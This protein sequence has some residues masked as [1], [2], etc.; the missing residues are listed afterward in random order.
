MSRYL[1]VVPPLVGHVNPLVGV[2]A[3]LS[4]RGHDVAWAGSPELVT[5]LAGSAARVFPCAVPTTAAGELVA[6]PPELRGLAALKFLWEEFLAPLAE[7]MEPG[8][9]AAVQEFAPDV[10]V[11][12][13]QALAGALVAEREGLPWATSATTSAEFAGALTSMPLVD[14]WVSALFAGLRV[15]LGVAP[16]GP[17]P[18]YSPH[19]VLAF[20]TQELAGAPRSPEAVRF[21]G[22]SLAGRGDVDGFPWAW[23]DVDRRLALVSLGTANVDAGEAFLQACVA[24]ARDR[25]ER[26]QT[27]V[28]DPGGLLGPS[29]PDDDVLVLPHVPQLALLQHCA[30]VVCHAGHNTVCEALWHGV[31][32]VVAPIRDDQPVVAE[33]VVAAEA[34]VRVRFGRTSPERLGAALDRALDDPLL[35][36]GAG[37]VRTSFRA[38]GGAASAADALAQLAVA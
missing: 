16:D 29:Q 24:A 23:R 12:D 35:R 15:R 31:P 17:D 11:A 37:R 1:L 26:L 6:R 27:V 18:R 30:A 20:T 19:L 38:A 25:A 5:R 13:Q 8:V 4:A 3:E 32:L 33:Q 28:L 2:A 10:V 36:S 14:A 9:G 34:G 21:V 22:P 7:V